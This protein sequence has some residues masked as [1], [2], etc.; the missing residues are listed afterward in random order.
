MPRTDRAYEDNGLLF[1]PV[2]HPHEH[3]KNGKEMERAEVGAGWMDLISL[4]M[5]SGN[6]SRG[7]GNTLFCLVSL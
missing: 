1:F 6:G 7:C 3:E 5:D 4:H 2:E